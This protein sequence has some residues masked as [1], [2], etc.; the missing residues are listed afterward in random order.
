MNC[1]AT[2]T[3]R[4]YVCLV[5]MQTCLRFVHVQIKIISTIGAPAGVK[6]SDEKAAGAIEAL[7]DHWFGCVRQF[8]S[9][10]ADQWTTFLESGGLPF[11]L[12]Q[13]RVWRCCCS[14]RACVCVFLPA[15]QHRG[16][17]DDALVLAV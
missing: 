13:A 1:R 3:S 14:L 11:L 16:D 2:Q 5:C 10:N 8:R 12:A 17:P 6:I 15:R 4:V 7:R 9:L